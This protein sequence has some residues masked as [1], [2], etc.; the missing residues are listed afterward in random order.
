MQLSIAYGRSA[1]G[2]FVAEVGDKVWAE[3]EIDLE[4][5][6]VDP[7]YRRRII[8]QLRAEAVQRR[9]LGLSKPAPDR[10]ARDD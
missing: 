5:V 8:A 7:D 3:G 4:R 10:S 2:V 6:I 1:K 9:G